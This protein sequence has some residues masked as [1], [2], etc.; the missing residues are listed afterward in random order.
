MLHNVLFTP[1]FATFI[2][3]FFF[4]D[5]IFMTLLNV[6][7]KLGFAVPVPMKIGSNALSF[8]VSKTVLVGPKLIW[9]DQIDLDLT[10][11]FLS[12]PK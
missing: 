4:P 11:I 2:K 6:S 5:L 12:Q 8:Y 10:I 1:N 3:P 7:I 9:S